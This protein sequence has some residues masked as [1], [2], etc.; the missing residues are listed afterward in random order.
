M[1][2]ADTV[3]EAKG[4]AYGVCKSSAASGYWQKF[5]RPDVFAA[6]IEGVS[7]AFSALRKGDRGESVK[8]LQKALTAKGFALP[9]YGADGD[10]GSETENAVKAFQRAE[11]LT[12][13]GIAGPNTNAAL[14]GG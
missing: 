5:A 11:K 8:T 1:D 7:A 10:F 2:D 6:E 13:D 12:V 3:I 14:F 9:K 4:R